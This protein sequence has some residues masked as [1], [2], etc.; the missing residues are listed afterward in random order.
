VT[1]AVEA[2]LETLRK[3]AV[4][5]AQDAADGLELQIDVVSG[6]AL[7]IAAAVKWDPDWNRVEVRTLMWLAAQH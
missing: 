3:F 4:Q 6:A 7:T 1:Y 2:K 5:A